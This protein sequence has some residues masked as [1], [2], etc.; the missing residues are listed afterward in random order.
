MN[1]NLHVLSGD[2]KEFEPLATLN[3]SHLERKLQTVAPLDAQTAKNLSNTCLYIATSEELDSLE[4]GELD[5]RSFICRG[6]LSPTW[7]TDATDILC[8]DESISSERIIAAVANAFNRYNNWIS[9]VQNALYGN[10]N[11]QAIGKLAAQVFENPLGMFDSSFQYLF[12]A[13]DHCTFELSNDYIR[14]DIKSDPTPFPTTEID[15]MDTAF[16]K[17][18]GAQE[19]VLLK[20]PFGHNSL[21]CNVLIN[22]VSVGSVYLDEIGAPITNRDY[23]LL[24]VLAET[25][26]HGTTSVLSPFLNAAYTVEQHLQELING[27]QIQRDTLIN[28]VRLLGW[29]SSDEIVCLMIRPK[30]SCPSQLIHTITNRIAHTFDSFLALP[31]EEDIVFVINLVLFDG[32]V[33]QAAEI[34]TTTFGHRKVYKGASNTFFYLEDVRFHCEEAARALDVALAHTNTSRVEY[35]AD[36]MLESLLSDYKADKPRS[37]YCPE[38]LIKLLR[39]DKE[40]ESDLTHILDV[41]LKNNMSIVEAARELFLHRNTLSYKLEKIR[42]ILAIDL[43]DSDNRL[44]LSLSLKLIELETA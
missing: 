5:G 20:T 17:A 11:L 26:A 37:A 44:L 30:E 25:L 15:L 7:K 22:G 8:V 43:E 38:S 1:L 13:V 3:S 28:A 12:T 29:G 32:P 36:H 33:H 42:S 40:H 34:I 23:C 14:R 2:L 6:A 19:P 41:Y 18:L 39:Y 16:E 10:M 24:S 9:Q 4:S 27:K 21:I 31:Y 35:F